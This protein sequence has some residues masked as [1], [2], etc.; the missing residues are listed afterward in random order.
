MEKD[1][2][3]KIIA[4]R[5]GQGLF[6][7]DCY[8][9]GA[10]RLKEVQDPDEPEVKFPSKP[11]KA[12]DIS[13][14]ICE[15]CEAIIGDPKVTAEKKRELE[16]LREQRILQME[17]AVSDQFKKEDLEE[18]PSRQG[19]HNPPN[20]LEKKRDLIDLQDMVED[21]SNKLSFIES[22]FVQQ[23]PG[24]EPEL[25][26][27]DTSGLCLILRDIQDDLDM[28]VDELSEKQR[29]ELIVETEMS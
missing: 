21:S 8:H 25:S 11:I 1:N 23:P 4:Y 9:A 29:Q 20:R 17:S 6:C 24:K 14:Y 15:D 10:R 2:G 27:D 16:A 19:R 18:K 13:I 22:F 3:E 5:I 26:D 28:V 12:G 7:P